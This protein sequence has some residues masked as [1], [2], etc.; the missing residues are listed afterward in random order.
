MGRRSASDDVFSAIADPTRRALLDA[1]KEREKTVTSLAKPF[2]MSLPAIS[3]HLKVLREVGLVS[4]R[5]EGRERY[6]RV[7]PAVLKRVA[8]WVKHYEVF[9]GGKLDALKRHRSWSTRPERQ[10]RPRTR[11][12]T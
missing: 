8:N 9:W 5:R 11:R 2:S 6:Y 4:E 12:R 3:Q 7:R 1:L 10:F